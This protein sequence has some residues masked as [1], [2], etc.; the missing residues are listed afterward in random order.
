MSR[1]RDLEISA[2]RSENA[3]K[4]KIGRYRPMR[5]SRSNREEMSD[6]RKPL[7]PEQTPPFPDEK[8]EKRHLQ[9]ARSATDRKNG[10]CCASF[11]TAKGAYITQ[12]SA[13][14]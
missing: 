5:G 2:A 3:V 10:P 8:K 12:K 11:S 14:S 7:V 9:M 4:K 13:T 6:L 1:S